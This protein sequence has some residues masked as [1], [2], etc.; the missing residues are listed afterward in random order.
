MAERWH[1]DI[2]FGDLDS[3]ISSPKESA[4]YQSHEPTGSY[5]SVGADDQEEIL[6]DEEDTW[7]NEMLAGKP[8][9]PVPVGLIHHTPIVVI[10]VADISV[11]DPVRTFPQ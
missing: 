7:L 1:P 5:L 8:A 10:K 11:D 6:E 4:A 2:S 9:A 3:I